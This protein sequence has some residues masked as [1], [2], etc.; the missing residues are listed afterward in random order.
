MARPKVG[1]T[2]LFLLLAWPSWGADYAV[3]NLSDYYRSL[4]M[5]D[6]PRAS[7][8]GEGDAWYADETETDDSGN[9]IAIITD[10]RPDTR[11]LPDGTTIIRKHIPPGTKFVVPK[12]K[13]R[14]KPIPN[15][16]DHTIIFIGY[17]NQVLCYEPVP[18]I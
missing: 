14:K 10:T 7:C 4:M 6:N 5:P 15:P 3:P 11:R 9:L 8:C 18:R 12:S 16:T 1:L 2:A 13:I 17:S